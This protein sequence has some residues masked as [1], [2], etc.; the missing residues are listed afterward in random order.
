MF[1]LQRP[2]NANRDVARLLDGFFGPAAGFR[3]AGVPW[4][5]GAY[6]R[7][8]VSETD[9]AVHVVAELPGVKQDQIDIEVQADV[10]RISGEKKDERVVNEHNYHAT[11]RSFGRFDRSIRLP[12]EVDGQQ[13]EA[14]FA[15]GVLS[16]SLPKVKPTGTQKVA[17]KAAN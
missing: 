14:T 13:A 15:D 1:L 12:A 4:T 10:L 2:V 16:I 5:T 17:I 9:A 3:P 11:E 7:L 8:D 6:P